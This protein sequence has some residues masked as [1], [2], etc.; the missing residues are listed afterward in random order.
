M[1]QKRLRRKGFLTWNTGVGGHFSTYYL[2]GKTQP[3]TMSS[4]PRP[5]DSPT[6][7]QIMGTGKRR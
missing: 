2:K 1:H 4:A 7:K 6:V 3:Y 5:K